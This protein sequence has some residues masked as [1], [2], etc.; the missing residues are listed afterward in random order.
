MDAYT[1]LAKDL[2]VMKL[3]YSR[4]VFK[5]QGAVTENERKLIS[6]AVGDVDYMSPA[7][8]MKVAK[9]TEI[10]ARNRADQ[11]KLWQQ[12]EKSGRTWKQYRDSNELKEL[13]RAQFYRT[14][15][16]FGQ[17]DAL[18]PSDAQRP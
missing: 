2:E 16:A 8:L 15:K 1:R 18:W 4:K 13:Q 14:A 5:G 12:M 7:N 10:E 3:D 17:K 9:A 11:D 6:T